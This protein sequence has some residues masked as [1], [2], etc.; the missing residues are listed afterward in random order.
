MS[1]DACFA[2]MLG[3]NNNLALLFRS[4]HLKNIPTSGL[5]HRIHVDSRPF[6]TSK[7]LQNH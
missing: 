3:K 1:C 2:K 6:R 4:T 7:A 5:T